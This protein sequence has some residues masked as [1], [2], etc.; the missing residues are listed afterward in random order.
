MD[1]VNPGPPATRLRPRERSAEPAGLQRRVHGFIALVATV[2]GVA[3]SPGASQAQG[4]VVG[5]VLED[6]TQRPIPD[7]TLSMAALN[8]SV[9]SDSL[10]RF[11]LSAIP[12]GDHV[13]LVRALGYGVL[14]TELTIE[15]NEVIVKD[16]TLARAAQVLAGTSVTA[17]PATSGK[18]AGFME[19]K[20]RGTGHFI[21]RDKLA[22]AEG[23]FR[24][25]GELIGMTPGTQLKRG[26]S[27]AWVASGRAVNQRGGGC[28]FCRSGGLSAAD[29]NAG[30]PP[31]CYMDVYLD[32]AMVFNSA[33]PG[34]G[35]FDVNSIQPEQLEG[36]EVYSSASQVPAQYNRTA[37]GCG[38]I[39][40]WTR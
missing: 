1:T 31:A 38:V 8:K 14:R 17:A 4:E 13:L 28:A 35:L 18:M 2:V 27:K 7:A 12:P 15:S 19:R 6:S 37:N 10:G 5:R 23:G 3:L 25:T 30:A 34:N 40:L 33:Q 22:D 16:F 39:L 11:T 21:T 32:G 29:R 26:G 24:R 20:E 36:I 9:R